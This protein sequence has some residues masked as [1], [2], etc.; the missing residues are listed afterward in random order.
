MIEDD[1]DLVIFSVKVIKHVK[2]DVLENRSDSGLDV[3]VVYDFLH[4]LTRCREVTEMKNV[5]DIVIMKNVVHKE[6]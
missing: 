6:V 3:L 1:N 2:K 5:F 4:N